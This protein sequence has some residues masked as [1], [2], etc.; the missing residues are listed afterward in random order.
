MRGSDD[1]QE[2]ETEERYGA[3]SNFV[4]SLVTLSILFVLVGYL[5]GNML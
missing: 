4:I 3:G 2:E 5:I 1:E